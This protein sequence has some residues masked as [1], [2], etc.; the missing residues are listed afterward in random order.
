MIRSC[1]MLTDNPRYTH[2][3]NQDDEEIWYLTISEGEVEVGN[4][5]RRGGL[6]TDMSSV[7]VKEGQAWGTRDPWKIEVNDPCGMS[8]GAGYVRGG[9]FNGGNQFRYVAQ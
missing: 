7:A 2:N 4:S 1:T 8:W 5:H 3:D 6:H 9:T